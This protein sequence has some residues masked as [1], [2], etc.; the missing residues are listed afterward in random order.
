MLDPILLQTFLAVAQTRSFIQA[1]ERLGREVVDR[2]DGFDGVDN[3]DRAGGFNSF[4]SFGGD[5]DF[6]D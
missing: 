5:D 1:A 4:D 3:F 2:V 6:D